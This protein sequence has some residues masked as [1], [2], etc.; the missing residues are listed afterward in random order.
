MGK[1]PAVLFYTGDF[2]TGTSFFN[3]EQRGKYIKLLCEQHQN[4]HIPEEHMIEICKTY[5]S[6][7]MKKFAKDSAGMYF[8]ERMEAETIKRKTYSESRRINRIGSQKEEKQTYDESYDK[9][10]D[11][12]MTEHMENDNDND[13]INVIDKE[14]ENLFNSTVIYFDENCRPKTENQ[15]KEWCDTLDKLVRL[16]KHTPEHIKNIIKRT[17][18]DD[19]WRMNF[20]SVLKLRKKNKEGI[21]YFT[22]FENK[23]FKNNG[24]SRIHTADEYA[25]DRI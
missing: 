8:N 19:F 16:D 1:D 23:K 5:D 6:P 24:Q 15:K 9:T 21:M 13:N 17:R 12:V 11:S 25:A 4:G 20:L 14:I 2:L 10:Y 18:M 3:D 7:V 22:V